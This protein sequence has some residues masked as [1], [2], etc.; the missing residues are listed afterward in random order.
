MTM[1]NKQTNN[2]WTWLKDY[3]QKNN[4]S[5]GDVAEALKWQKTRVSELLCGKRDFPV[6]K[7]FPAAQFF[8]LDLEELTK[9]NSGYT[10][11]IPSTDGKKPLSRAENNLSVIDIVR[12]SINNKGIFYEIVGKQMISTDI[13]NMFCLSAP[14]NIKALIAAGDAMQ[15]TIGDGDLV[16]ADVSVTSPDADGLYLFALEGEIFIK[17]LQLDN[18]NRTALIISDNTLYPPIR[19]NHPEKLKTIGKIVSVTKPCR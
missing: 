5:Q 12:P 8:N 19:V 11:E 9:Y 14:E 3:M 18:F 2:K 1:T 7:V 17:R 4:I 16:W 10:R 13:F 6:N 15:P